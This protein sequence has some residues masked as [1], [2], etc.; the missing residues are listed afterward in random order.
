LRQGLSEKPP[1]GGTPVSELA[2]KIKEL[3]AANTVEGT[4]E[5]TGVRK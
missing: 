3:R 2:E 4:P 1:E 5:R